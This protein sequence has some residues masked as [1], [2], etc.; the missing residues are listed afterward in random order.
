MSEEVTQKLSEYG[1]IFGDNVCLVFFLNGS[2][3]VEIG[4]R[5]YRGFFV[6]SFDNV[7]EFLKKD[8]DNTLRFAKKY[9]WD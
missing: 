7:S 5:G 9:A 1:A 2:G 4:I 6:D 3:R 8:V